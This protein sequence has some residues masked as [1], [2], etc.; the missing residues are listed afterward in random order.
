[1]QNKGLIKLFAFL[2]GLVSIYQLSYTFIT[3]KIENDAEEYAINK[4]SNSEEDYLSK[5]EE[6][7]LSYLDSIGGNSILGYTT[8]NEAKKK[9]LNKGLDLKGGINVTL[10]ISVKDILKGLADNTNS[11]IFNKALADADAASKSSDDTYVDLFFEAFDNI[12]G[13]TKLASPDIFA[14]KGLSD[15]VNFQMT[16]DE[17]KPIIRRKIDESI[18][19]AFEVLRER[20]DGFGVTQP[21]I[22]RE[23][24]SGRILV[25]LP[26]ARDIARAQELLSSTAQ[27]EFWETYEQNNPSF[28]NFIVAANEKLKSL[29]KT[30]KVEE[31]VKEES[32]L[33]SLLSD[34]TDS[35]DL[36]SQVNPLYDILLPANP[37]THAMFRAAVKDTAKVGE[38]L[39]MPEI[40]RLLPAD[41][42]YT[43]F[44]WERPST[45]DV[46]ILDL[47]A[48][49]SNRSNTPRIS[50]DVVSDARDTYDEYNKPA[51]SM[52]MNSR[53]AKEWQKLTSDA[54]VNNTG[55]A[56]VLDNK[57]YTAPGCSVVGG[58]SGG[59]TE[60]TG[61]FTVEETKDIANVLRAG[62][63][64]AKAE[65]IQSN[66]VGPSLGQEAIDSGFSSFLIAMAIVLIWMVFYY[67]K[68]GLFADVALLLNILLIFGVLTSLSA[69]LTLPG[70]AGIVLTIGMA[71]DANVLIFER[72]KEEVARG[73]GK[74]QAVADGFGNALS[75]ILDANITTGLTALILFL[76]GSGPIKGFATTL[77]IGIITSLFTA[78]FIT[79]LLVDWYLS[80]KE[81]KLDFSTSLTKNL[82]TNLN[83]DFLAKRKIAYV[84]STVMVGIGLFSL[85]FGP[86]LQQGVD[87]IGG[88]SYQVRFEHEVSASEIASELNT[89]FGSGTN[90][91]TYGEANQIKITTPYKVEA[92]GVE[93]DNEIQDKLYT[94]LQ[95]YLPDGTT[96]SDFIV[97]SADKTVGIMQSI[98]VGPTIADDIKKNAFLAILGSLAVVFLYILLRFRKWQFSL[99]AVVAVFHDVLIVLGI[100]SLTGKIMPFNMEIDQAFIAAILTVIG[101]SLND[102]V[103]VFDRIRE[104]I[105]ERGW[106]GGDNVNSAVNSTLGRTLN[107]SLTTMVVLLAI[108][109]FGGE[110]LR[111]F[112]FAMIVGVV[113]G[114]YSSVFIATPVM[115]DTLKR[116]IASGEEIEE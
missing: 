69:V 85:F 34:V 64:P 71:V 98:K 110:S 22:Q 3:A 11:P 9:E 12:K 24:N 2:F 103:V 35:L 88:R 29:V 66:V 111:G 54:N 93:V 61:S 106:R 65:I 55:I 6:V 57:V 58:I 36:A 10:Q 91:K 50:G 60:I 83:I 18:V 43:K 1:M 113:V 47:Y 51:V 44:L 52:S 41:I 5:R 8:Y 100:F 104:I 42:Q 39:R 74:S 59:G 102:T 90:V 27:L 7:E 109:V 23:G 25:E 63:L 13:D 28:G 87:F 86:G 21:N 62:K 33:D 81:R 99:G 49:K 108:F 45:S 26:G 56:V 40:R 80:G 101:Y 115:F 72:I 89:V 73:K 4:I 20:I 15:E 79:R 46:E 14:N 114:T 77:L 38:Y 70:I 30:E 31:P 82:F 78:I 116:K 96:K 32:E 76:F 75:S 94:S 97:G 53:G 16:D 19:S 67:G 37:G 107:T 68:A 17:V 92:E 48:L 105:G 95:K 112:M 84:I